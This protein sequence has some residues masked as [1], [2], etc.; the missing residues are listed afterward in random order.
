MAHRAWIK[1]G[2]IRKP[3]PHNWVD[4]LCE[5]IEGPGHTPM[6]QPG[7]YPAAHL[8]QLP[9][10][11]GR[12]EARESHP[13]FLVRRQPGPE[14]VTAERERDLLVVPAAIAVLA[15][16]DP[17]LIGVKLQPDFDQPRRERRP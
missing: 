12:E 15:I 2:V 11:N 10:R 6:Q 16:H 3:T 8:A 7:R 13:P 1:R 9:L 14:G 4:L 17:G 5:A